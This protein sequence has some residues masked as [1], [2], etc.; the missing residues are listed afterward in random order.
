[1]ARYRYYL[2]MRP[3]MPGAVPNGREVVD[4]E[5]FGDRTLVPHIGMAWGWVEYE[6]P[7]TQ[8]QIDGYEL[9]EQMFSCVIDFGDGVRGRVYTTPEIAIRLRKAAREIGA[10]L[11]REE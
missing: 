4:S 9:A 3:P 10:T 5:D 11:V 6:S 8:E 7:L 2:R 1:M